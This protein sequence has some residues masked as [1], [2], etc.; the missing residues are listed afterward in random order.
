[1][2]LFVGFIYTNQPES[3]YWRRRLPDVSIYPD[4]FEINCSKG[5]S[6]IINL[7]ISGSG[8]NVIEGTEVILDYSIDGWYPYRTSAINVSFEPKSVIFQR[9]SVNRSDVITFGAKAIVE[10]SSLASDGNYYLWI[11]GKSNRDI[12]I[13]KPS[14]L[15]K[16]GEGGKPPTPPP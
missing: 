14:I 15:I 6:T 12:E 2:F 7:T 13:V 3:K 1:M 8:T 10:I 5:N 11:T 9:S 16:I 4:L